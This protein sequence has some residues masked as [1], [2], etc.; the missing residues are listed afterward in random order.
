MEENEAIASFIGKLA[1]LNRTLAEL[2]KSGDIRLFTQMN[3]ILKEMYRIQHGSEIA[4]FVAID[5][6]CTVIYKNFD[7]IIS[8]LR[9]T[10]NGEIDSGAQT[11]LNRLLHNID[12]ATVNIAEAFGLI[13]EN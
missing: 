8:V 4:A 6:D 7:M 11:A 3:G 13:S 9:T 1:E 2:F 12:K 10:E 5:E